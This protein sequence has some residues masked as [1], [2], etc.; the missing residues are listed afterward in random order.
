M[1]LRLTF[2]RP[3]VALGITS[4]MEVFFSIY[5]KNVEKV[6]LV[7]LI[8]LINNGLLTLYSSNSKNKFVLV[9]MVLIVQQF[10]QRI[11]IITNFLYIG[12]V[13]L[14]QHWVFNYDKFNVTEKDIIDF[15]EKF[16]VLNAREFKNYEEEGN[17]FKE[18]LNKCVLI[19]HFDFIYV[20]GRSYT[21]SQGG[22][23]NIL[24]LHS[25]TNI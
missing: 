14:N 6:S 15:L 2:R 23:T 20:Q 18:C 1:C 24:F 10:F 22:P 21:W 19:T 12:Q 3:Y 5:G 17:A 13:S 7:L 25:Y 16:R 11:S 8:T 4:M 9:Q